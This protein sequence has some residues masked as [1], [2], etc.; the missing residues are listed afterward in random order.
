MQTILTVVHLF[1]AIGLV[2]LVLIQHG[3]GADAG[4]AF[5]SGASATVFGARGSANFLSRSTA[6]L[7]ALF[8]V[9]SIALAYYSTR[10]VE[11]E[12]LMEGVEAPPV[13]AV[14]VQREESG[15]P[16]AEPSRGE[17]PAAGDASMVPAPEEEGATAVA[18]PQAAVS[19]PESVAP[20][21]V[22][23][24]A[25]PEPP[26]ADGEPSKPRPAG[27]EPQVPGQ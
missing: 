5:G 12:S 17:T 24:G 9:T 6:A 14:E 20:A 27:G 2:G 19:P 18:V 23:G 7:A 1:L 16:P 15:V 10:V 4:A 22:E 3:K 11:P 8:F 13:P 21:G 26:S 25:I